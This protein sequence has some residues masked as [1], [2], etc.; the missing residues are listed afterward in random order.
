MRSARTNI[1]RFGQADI[2][3][4]IG[5][6]DYIPDRHLVPI[7]Q[8]LR[9]TLKP[10]GVA[11]LAF[12]DETGYD[13][14]EYQWFVDWHFFQRDERQCFQLLCEAGFDPGELEVYRDQ[15]GIIMNW[16]AAAPTGRRF[17]AD[18]SSRSLA[19]PKVL[20]SGQSLPAT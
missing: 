19:G 1:S 18:R 3:Y 10:G 8:G 12:K 6:L 20:A 15:T 11:Y 13:A 17:R 2:I 5:L 4:S 14:C 16:V 9:G 7:L